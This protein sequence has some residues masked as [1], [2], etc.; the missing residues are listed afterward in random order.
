MDSQK[1]RLMRCLA[2]SLCRRKLSNAMQTVHNLSSSMVMVMAARCI[3]I[4]ALSQ[5]IVCCVG[6]SPAGNMGRSMLS[7]R[8]TQV[9]DAALK[10]SAGLEEHLQLNSEITSA[11]S[12]A[13]ASEA[14][15]DFYCCLVEETMPDY[16][17]RDCWTARNQPCNSKLAASFKNSKK[18][19]SKAGLKVTAHRDCEDDSGGMRFCVLPKA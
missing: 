5:V 14:R 18:G 1:T 10:L 2:R 17:K 12:E 15:I 4:V 8:M 13:Y 11:A 9:E 16:T 7:E 3:Q 19:Y 6:V